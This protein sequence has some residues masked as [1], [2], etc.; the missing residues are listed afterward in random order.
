MKYYVGVKGTHLKTIGIVFNQNFE[1]ENAYITGPS[2]WIR[3][4]WPDAY[5]NFKELDTYLLRTRNGQRISNN[6]IACIC[7]GM[8]GIGRPFARKEFQEKVLKQCRW[9]NFNII[10]TT[11]AEIALINGCNGP[12]GIAIISGTG[13]IVY[14][15]YKRQTHRVG[16]VGSILGDFGSCYDIGLSGIRTLLMSNDKLSKPCLELNI[17]LLEHFHVLKI[18][19]LI[20]RIYS[21]IVQFSDFKIREQIAESAK[22]IIDRFTQGRCHNCDLKQCHCERIIKDAIKYLIK[23]YQ[24]TAK[25]LGVGKKEIPVTLEGGL[26]DYNRKLFEIMHDR[27]IAVSP[28]AKI[29]R[30]KYDSVLG[31]LFFAFCKKD[32]ITPAEFLNHPCIPD[33][34]IIKKIRENLNVNSSIIT[35]V[36]NRYKDRFLVENKNIYFKY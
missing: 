21:N 14:G 7:I 27:I 2:T 18:E 17:K 31:A 24:V 5:F 28:G 22:F 20:D 9:D 33:G 15:R 35:D 36:E 1:F 13:S 6:D 3:V 11:D 25:I 8:S 4:K 29:Q 23:Y 16:G 19:D 12:E 34:D 32:D 10:L 30:N 26:F